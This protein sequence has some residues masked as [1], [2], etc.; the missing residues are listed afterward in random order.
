MWKPSCSEMTLPF[1]PGENGC[2]AFGTD[3]FTPPD[4]EVADLE[5]EGLFLP[6][7]HSDARLWTRR[8]L[9]NDKLKSTGEAK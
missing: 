3:G 8:Q 6:G 4:D 5:V 1:M 7:G 9:S 2:L